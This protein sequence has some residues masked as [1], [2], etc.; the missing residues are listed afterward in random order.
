MFQPKM[1]NI[2]AGKF[3]V[4]LENSFNRIQRFHFRRVA[5]VK[6]NLCLDDL[7]SSGDD[8]YNMGVYVCHRPN[9]T[10]SQFLSLTN[11]NLLRT[12]DSCASVQQR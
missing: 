7:Q 6:S 9:I 12:E 10:K 2:T 11:D 4:A 3:D 1:F 8:P 5:A